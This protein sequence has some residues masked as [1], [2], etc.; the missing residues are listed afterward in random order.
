MIKDKNKVKAG[1]A[2]Q[3]QRI[4]NHNKTRHELFVELSGF[5]DK[6]MLDSIQFSKNR[7]S[8]DSLK[9]LIRNY[10]NK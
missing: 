7:W 8:N 9:Q 3:K 5:I 10:K 6:T 1:K 4:L 2:G